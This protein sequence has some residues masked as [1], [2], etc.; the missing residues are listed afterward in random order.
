MG[1]GWGLSA[2]RGIAWVL[3]SQ[4]E[5]EFSDESGYFR[6]AGQPLRTAF[7]ALDFKD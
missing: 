4:T 5:S 2:E 3:V 6:I 1:M 7:D